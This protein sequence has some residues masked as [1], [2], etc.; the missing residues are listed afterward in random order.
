MTRSEYQYARETLGWT[1][2]R[3]AQ[4]LG[5]KR[6]SPYR[7]AAGETIPEP[8]ARLLRLLVTMRLTT[9]EKKFNSFVDQLLY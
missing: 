5:V 1:H 9:S 7:Y 2:K 4:V 3:M 8:I 6:R